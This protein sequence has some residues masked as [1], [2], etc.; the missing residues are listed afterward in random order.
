MRIG[1]MLT[2]VGIVTAR[3]MPLLGIP[4]LLAGWTILGVMGVRDL[5]KVAS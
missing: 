3:H 5:K 2:V 1:L 4:C